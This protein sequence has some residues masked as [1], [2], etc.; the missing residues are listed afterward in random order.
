MTDG[1]KRH[2]RP[3]GPA[4]EIPLTG[5]GPLV[6]ATGDELPATPPNWR[7]IVGLSSLGGVVLGIVVAITLIGFVW[8]DDE[9]N[10]GIT[11][12]PTTT[13]D[14]FD[15]A[16]PLTTPPTL[17]RLNPV[18]SPTVTT[19]PMTEPRNMLDT[20]TTP[21]PPTFVG[22]KTYGTIPDYPRFTGVPD[23]G[24]DSFDLAIAVDAVGADVAR[25]SKTHI[26]IGSTDNTLEITIVRDPINDRYGLTSFVD[27]VTEFVVVDVADGFTYSQSEPDTWVA[28]SNADVIANLG[29]SDIGVF[30]DRLMLGPLRPDTLDSATIEPLTLVF[31]EGEDT[32]ARQFAI[33]LPGDRVPEWQ[34]YPLGSSRSMFPDFLPE[35]LDYSAYVDDRGELILVTGSATIADVTQLVIHRLET[36]AEPKIV[37]LPDPALVR[38]P[39]DISGS[40][41]ARA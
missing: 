28:V 26:E 5:D 36:L 40:T 6:M 15:L 41:V 37:S 2:D 31:F 17:P 3:D 8:D 29:L 35:R 16:T 23:G 12:G 34:R 24:L 39:N 20:S 38:T 1:W 7:K 30:L 13:I 18:G 10:G 19:D 14:N 11:G 32:I 21:A 25:R 4:V 22:P 27:G 33:E 9:R